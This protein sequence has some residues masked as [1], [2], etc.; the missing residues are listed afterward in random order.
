M[1]REQEAIKTHQPRASRKGDPHLD[2][3]GLPDLEPGS[4]VPLYVQL[5]DRL[6]ELVRSHPATSESGR[7]PSEAECMERFSIS[8][9][10]VRQ[11]LARLVSRGLVTRGR[12]RGTFIAPPRLDRDL[13]RTVED[14]MRSANRAVSFKLLD[15]QSV[16]PTDETR[17]ALGLSQKQR[18]EHITRLRLIEGV[19]VGLEERFVSSKF[20]KR[21]TLKALRELS[22]VSLIREITGE[23]PMFFD[24]TVRSIPAD[25]KTATALGV[26]R[27]SPLLLSQHTYYSQA[28]ESLLHG[29]ALFRGTHFQL[30][31]QMPI[32]DATDG[33]RLFALPS[34]PTSQQKS[35]RKTSASPAPLQSPNRL[36]RTRK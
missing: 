19:S 21:I 33:P 4:Y 7:L 17:A 31:F 15:W 24:A 36:L 13:G 12:G 6:E 35:R 25:P 11:A 34:A 16:V 32:V 22:I 18:V 27:G 9:P 29:V 10:T 30:S 23:Q 28:N 20:A 1:H 8:R 5:A 3:V 26:K 14:E 2:I